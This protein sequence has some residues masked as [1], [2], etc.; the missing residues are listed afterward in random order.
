MEQPPRDKIDNMPTTKGDDM[1]Y[2]P[3]PDEL[4]EVNKFADDPILEKGTHTCGS[5]AIYPPRAE[6][7]KWGD[8]PWLFVTTHPTD[9]LPTKSAIIKPEYVMAVFE[10]P[11]FFESRYLWDDQKHLRVMR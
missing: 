11:H 2:T 6:P 4:L 7:D 10:R 1:S 8:L 5:I 3:I 9:D